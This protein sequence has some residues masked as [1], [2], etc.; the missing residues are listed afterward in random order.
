MLKKVAIVLVNYNGEKFQNECIESI[1]RMDY[2]NYDIIVVDN[3]TNLS[4]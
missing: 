3:G 2:N 4:S 1:N